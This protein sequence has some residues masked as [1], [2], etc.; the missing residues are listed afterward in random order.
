MSTKVKYPKPV[1]W[2]HDNGLFAGIA[3]TRSKDVADRWL[4]QGWAI[5]PLFEAPPAPI[6]PKTVP[7]SV[8]DVIYAE[9]NGFV[10]CDAD[11]QTIWDACCAAMLA[12]A[13]GGNQKC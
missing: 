11:P 4:A 12:A 1:A 13:S 9:C 2:R 7:R 8:F 5:T 10:D 6:M 3:I